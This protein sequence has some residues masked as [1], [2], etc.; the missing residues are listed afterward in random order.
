MWQADLTYIRV[1]HGFVYLACVLDGFT[2]EIVGW[3]VSKFMNADLPLTAL[4][5]ALAVR[6]PAPG[7]LHHSD[8]RT[9]PEGA[10]LS[11]TRGAIRQPNIR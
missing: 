4:N 1:E 5:I 3:A 9:G 8:Q 10:V 7:L 6:R 11:K 2:R